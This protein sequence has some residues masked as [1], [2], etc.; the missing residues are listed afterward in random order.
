MLRD[1][2]L[3]RSNKGKY[4]PQQENRHAIPHCQA[5]IQG[6]EYAHGV[7]DRRIFSPP[8]RL[9]PIGGIRFELLIDKALSRNTIQV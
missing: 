5:P 4:N 6:P 1:P 7:V 8:C 3:Y 9:L 2:A